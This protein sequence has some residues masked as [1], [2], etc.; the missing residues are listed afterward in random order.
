MLARGKVTRKG[1]G[2]LQ[3]KMQWFPIFASLVKY[4]PSKPPLLYPPREFRLRLNCWG[5]LVIIYKMYMC[6][7]FYFIIF[8]NIS[9]I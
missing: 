8:K 5:F 9:M 1:R 4:D 2:N 3:F 6:I 7:S